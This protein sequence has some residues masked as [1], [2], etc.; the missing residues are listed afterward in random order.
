MFQ[1]SAAKLKKE[2]SI[3]LLDK[4]CLNFPD[5]DEGL[6][7]HVIVYN[8]LAWNITTIINTTVTFPHAA[9]FDDDGQPVPAQVFFFYLHTETLEYCKN[10]PDQLGLLQIQQ[11]AHSNATFDL[12]MLVELGGLQHRKYLIKVSEK[13]CSQKSECGWTYRAKGVLF[14]RRGVG[15]SSRT[16]RR[17][18]PVLNECYKLM[19]DQDTNLLHSITHL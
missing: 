9:V 1:I 19:F 2:L 11:S 10:N 13:P 16:G 15:R 17:L 4:I 5:V 7:Q 8:P 6:E 12:F 3:K 14:E 18:L